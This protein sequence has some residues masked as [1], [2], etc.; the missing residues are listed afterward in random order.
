MDRLSD[1]AVFITDDGFELAVP[2]LAPIMGLSEDGWRIQMAAGRLMARAE[3]G[4]GNDAGKW[5][6]TLRHARTR[7]EIVVHPDNTAY[8]HRLA[9][10]SPQY[11]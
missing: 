7:I 5:R 8:F 2:L 1:G 11:R 10:P 3:K 9:G 6:I 4:I